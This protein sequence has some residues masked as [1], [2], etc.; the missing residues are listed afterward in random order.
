MFDESKINIWKGKKQKFWQFA[1]I[2]ACQPKEHK[3]EVDRFTNSL[4]VQRNCK[5]QELHLRVFRPQL[6]C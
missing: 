3:S 1:G 6:A 5:T 2:H 4:Q